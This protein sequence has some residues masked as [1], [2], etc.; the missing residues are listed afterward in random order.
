MRKV[1]RERGWSKEE[2]RMKD[3]E[4]RRGGYKKKGGEMIQSITGIQRVCVRVCIMC[5][6]VFSRLM[7]ERLTYSFRVRTFVYSLFHD[8]QQYVLFQI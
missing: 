1:D 5:P 2:E 4:E 7:S 6:A 8:I 3:E